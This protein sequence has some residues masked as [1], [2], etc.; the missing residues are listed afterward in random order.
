MKLAP[1]T[2]NKAARI[3]GRERALK[4]ICCECHPF[5]REQR[6]TGWRRVRRAAKQLLTTETKK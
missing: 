1:D 6:T 5:A 4:F 3:Y 2:T